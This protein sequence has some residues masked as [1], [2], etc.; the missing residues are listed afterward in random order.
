MVG[1]SFTY[2]DNHSIT[3]EE[4]VFETIPH[5][6][7]ILDLD[8]SIGF[9]ASSNSQSELVVGPKVRN[10]LNQGNF[11]Y[12]PS[13]I[14]YYYFTFGLD[15]WARYQY[16]VGDD[17]LLNAELSLPVLAWVARSPYLGQDSNYIN[18]SSPLS[19]LA[20]VG[21]Y[22]KDGALQSWGKFQRVDLKLGYTYEV[23]SRLNLQADYN[24]NF[25]KTDVPSGYTSIENYLLIGAILKL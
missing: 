9:R 23:N 22:I 25:N 10:L 11:E 5:N 8:Y 7:N 19:S 4:I 17:H 20:I 13:G 16:R 24:L 21:N 18:N 3:G 6:F 12:G 2:L 14:G 1:D 15:F